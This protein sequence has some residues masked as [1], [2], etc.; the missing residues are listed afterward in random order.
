MAKLRLEDPADKPTEVIYATTDNSDTQF[1]ILALWAAQ[2]HDVPVDRTMRLI[3]NRFQT[4]QNSDGSWGYRYTNGGGQGE[5]PPWTAAA[6]S[7]WRSATASPATARR[8]STRS[9]TRGSS[10]ASPR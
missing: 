2:R 3:A 7:A 1:A 10:T 4:S 6:C 9:R 8:W 5:A